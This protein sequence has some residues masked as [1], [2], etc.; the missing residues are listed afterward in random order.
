MVSGTLFVLRFPP[1]LVSLYLISVYLGGQYYHETC[2]E[3]QVV[4]VM[5]L[6]TRPVRVTN[7]NLDE[8]LKMILWVRSR[9]ESG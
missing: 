5:C 8:P 9:G 7:Y 6:S 1:F 4:T 2:K 3:T